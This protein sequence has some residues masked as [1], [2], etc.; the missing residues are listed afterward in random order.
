[1]YELK[2]HRILLLLV[3]EPE[4]CFCSLWV[5]QQTCGV[6]HGRLR[7]VLRRIAITKLRECRWF[8]LYVI[9][10]LMSMRRSR[11]NWPQRI[12]VDEDEFINALK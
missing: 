3:S 2:Q 4:W 8:G 6:G 1:M 10:E 5:A 9:G 11:L 7:V 12:V